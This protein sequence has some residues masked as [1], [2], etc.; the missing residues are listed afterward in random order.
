M[1]TT[2]TTATELATQNIIRV[3]TSHNPRLRPRYDRFD[4]RISFRPCSEI[5]VDDE[6]ESEDTRNVCRRSRRIAPRIALGLSSPVISDIHDQFPSLSSPASSDALKIGRDTAATIRESSRSRSP[7]PPSQNS[8]KYICSRPFPSTAGSVESSVLPQTSD[9]S[10]HHGHLNLPAYPAN[11]ASSHDAAADPA[12]F[13]D[14]PSPGPGQA[15]FR[16]NFRYCNRGS[17]SALLALS[18]RPSCAVPERAGGA[19]P[20]PP[21]RRLWERLLGCLGASRAAAAD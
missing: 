20:P 7:S 21:R 8:D 19:Q 2:S 1:S 16:I 12:T 3:L 18:S 5:D 15:N 6:D 4:V 9:R 14:R 17:S 10:P 11:A 13:Q